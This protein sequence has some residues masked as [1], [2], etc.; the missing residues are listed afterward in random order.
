MAK[1]KTFF[2]SEEVTVTNSRF[3]VGSKTFAMSNITSVKAS[4]QEPK[5]LY[6]IG[7]IVLGV[8]VLTGSVGIGVVISGIGVAWLLMQKTKYHVTLTTAAGESSALGS[9]QREYIE[10]VVQALNEAIVARG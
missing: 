1:E 3:M 7:L 5:R 9:K 8:F 2:Q 10:K 4:E 6:S